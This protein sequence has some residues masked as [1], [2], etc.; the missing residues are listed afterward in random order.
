MKSD[1]KLRIEFE[2]DQ[3][4]Y[5]PPTKSHICGQSYAN[6]GARTGQVLILEKKEVNVRESMSIVQSETVNVKCPIVDSQCQMSNVRQSVSNVQ[7]ETANVRHKRNWQKSKAFPTNIDI[8]L[9]KSSILFS[10]TFGAVTPIMDF[11][12]WRHR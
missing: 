7:C 6:I 9:A 4:K 11:P 10:G 12:C 3:S 8:A 1:L 2:V 5:P